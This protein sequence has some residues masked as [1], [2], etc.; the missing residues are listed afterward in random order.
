MRHDMDSR[1]TETALEVLILSDLSDKELSALIE[2]GNLDGAA[3]RAK[4]LADAA[5]LDGGTATP[6]FIKAT[7]LH[8]IVRT[9]QA[10]LAELP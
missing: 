9:L 8:D 10:V 5:D 7:L 1:L 3:F 4:E 2:Q 6:Q